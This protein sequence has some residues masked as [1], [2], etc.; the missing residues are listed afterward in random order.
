MKGE[1]NRWRK[2]SVSYNVIVSPN[3]FEGLR[4]IDRDTLEKLIPCVFA[5]LMEFCYDDSETEIH[6]LSV[7]YRRTVM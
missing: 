1:E 5:S 6:I 4:Q 2:Q 7:R 3:A